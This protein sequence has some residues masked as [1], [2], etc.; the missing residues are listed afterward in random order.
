MRQFSLKNKLGEVYLLN[1]LD[2]FLHE[3]EGIGFTRNATFQKIGTNYK[4]VQDGFTQTPVKGKIMFKSDAKQSAYKRYLKFSRFLQEIPLLLVYRVPGGEFFQDCIP[5]SVDKTE[6]NAAFGMD[7]GITL[8]P[9]SMWYRELKETAQNSN[10]TVISE[11]MNESP[12]CL[13]FS[14]VTKSN[15]NLSW[16]QEVDGIE[17]MTGTLKNVT[18]AATDT[19]FIRT[20]TKEYQIYKVSSGGTKTNL[21][22][23]SD[24]GTGRFPFFYKGENEFIITGAT[25]IR[26]EGRELYETV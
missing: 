14:G 11:S 25:M 21:Y 22:D 7:V 2:N 18:I 13:S 20:D 3:P 19:V 10:V 17:V 15:A 24:F 8:T 9:L 4:M 1:S 16:S 12:C 6:I 5:G 26:V 23:K